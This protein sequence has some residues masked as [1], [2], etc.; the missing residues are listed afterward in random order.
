METKV[1]LVNITYRDFDSNPKYWSDEQFMNEAEEQGSV[2]TL[3]GFENA[4]NDEQILEI[5]SY[6][7]FITTFAL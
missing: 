3:K 2:Y 7:R 6:I 5:D 1:Y 4:F